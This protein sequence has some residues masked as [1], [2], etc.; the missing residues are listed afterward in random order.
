MTCSQEVSFLRN[1][2]ALGPHWD[3][4]V[5]KAYMKARFGG[6]FGGKC[7]GGRSPSEDGG[8]EGGFE[9]RASR[10]RRAKYDFDHVNETIYWNLGALLEK[11][12]IAKKGNFFSKPPQ[13]ETLP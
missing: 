2:S 1:F 4:E 5:C 9:N 11:L 12:M 7:F 13:F 8:G 10:N 6:G 3:R